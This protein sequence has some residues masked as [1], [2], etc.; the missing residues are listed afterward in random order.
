MPFDKQ[1]GEEGPLHRMQT[2]SLSPADTAHLKALAKKHQSTVNTLVQLAWGVLLHRYSGESQVMFGAVVSGRPAEIAEIESMVGL[3]INSIPVVAPFDGKMLL[4]DLIGYLHS[5]FQR[6][7]EYGYLPLTE[8]QKQ[9]RLNRS[10][11]LFDSLL[12]FE[13]YPLDEAI[14]LATDRR[15]LS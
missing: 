4:G 2:A 1:V 9:S 12:V 6:S 15:R 3:F 10:M 8:I 11:P 14:A 5:T 13:N 7:Q